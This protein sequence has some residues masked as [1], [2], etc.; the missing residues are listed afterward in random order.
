LEVHLLLA[1]EAGERGVAGKRRKGRGEEERGDT[2]GAK[3]GRRGKGEEERDGESE[4][5]D[6]EE[7]KEMSGR[8]EE[9]ER[10]QR[11]KRT[12]ERERCSC[13][14]NWGEHF[15]SKKMNI[16]QTHPSSPSSPVFLSSPLILL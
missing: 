13:E 10:S 4:S 15:F 1:R 3:R 6:V 8:S 5:D 9:V 12:G 16:A 14:R 2:I 11:K 7:E